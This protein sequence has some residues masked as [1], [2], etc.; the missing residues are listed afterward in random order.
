MVELLFKRSLALFLD[1]KG[2]IKKGGEIRLCETLA[3]IALIL[4]L[5]TVY[6]TAM[7]KDTLSNPYVDKRKKSKEIKGS[8]VFL[9]YVI[10]PLYTLA[11]I[12]FINLI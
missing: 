11:I 8:I 7:V 1:K 12:Y 4:P 3:T 10:F 9:T 6:L 5:F 2:F